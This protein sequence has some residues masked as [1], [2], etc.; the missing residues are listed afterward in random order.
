MTHK[1]LAT[2]ESNIEQLGFNRA[3]AQIYQ[4]VNAI[5]SAAKKEKLDKDGSLGWV[6]DE[7]MQ[8]LLTM[9]SPM[10]PHLAEEC[11]SQLGKEGLVSK[12]DWPVAE[13][14]ML[15]EDEY[16]ASYSDQRQ[17]NAAK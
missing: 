7:S 6:L 13:K 14:A 5:A 10:M 4:L 2:V 16:H 8:L 9:C 15:A 1:T 11:W 17:K 3:V 12:Q